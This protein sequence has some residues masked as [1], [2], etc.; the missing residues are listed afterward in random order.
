MKTHEIFIKV[1]MK[2][3]TN[4]NTEMHRLP[5][6]LL[7]SAG[8]GNQRK[9]ASLPSWVADWSSLPEA[10]SLS[11]NDGD[12]GFYRASGLFSNHWRYNSHRFEVEDNKYPGVRD[13]RARQYVNLGPE[14]YTIILQGMR[15]DIIKSLAEQTYD[16]HPA[17]V[18]LEVRL[19][20]II[21]WF[22]ET[23]AL[24]RSLS[25]SNNL[26][27]KVVLD[28]YWRTICG[29]RWI[30]NGFWENPVSEGFV[31]EY[32]SQ[33]QL[34]RNLLYRI[35]RYSTAG[36]T[37]DVQAQRESL[38][39]EVCQAQVTQFGLAVRQH[40]GHR[41]FAITE[42]GRMAL[43]PP[44]CEPGDLICVFKGAQ[45]PMLLRKPTAESEESVQMELD[46][47]MW[48]KWFN[49]M[50]PIPALVVGLAQA[51]APVSAERFKLVGDCYV[52]GIMLG[53]M[54]SGAGG[55]QAMEKRFD[56]SFILT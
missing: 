25:H 14:P 28:S 8:I 34:Y 7:P 32:K 24:A 12:V 41:R 30:L 5:L 56:E 4:E 48:Q 20:G 35:Q 44:L 11:F 16:P 45:T 54:L 22:D 47:K 50:Y 42:G 39:F 33:M 15:V 52:H 43:V 18:D 38:A 2:T 55:E 6:V 49:E 51:S 29:N 37:K 3:L 17:G 13:P 9:I 1:A 40:A 53:E 31:Q 36:S 26:T 23:L 19:K 21:A 10:L 27:D 46:P